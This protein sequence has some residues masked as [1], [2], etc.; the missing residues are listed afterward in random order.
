M[1]E[2]SRLGRESI[3]TSYALKEIL[4]AGVKVF[5][6]LENKERVLESAMDKIMLSLTSFSSEVER[7]RCRQRTHDALIRKV[8]MGHVAGGRVYGYD[9]VEIFNE[10]TDSSGEKKRQY[11]KLGVNENEAE[12]VRH[13]YQ[14]YADGWGVTKIAKHLNADAIPAPR[15]AKG[16]WAPSAIWEILHRSKYWGENIYNMYQN[17]Y[18]NGTQK[19]VKRPKE[20]WIINKDPK[21]RIISPEVEKRVKAR[22]EHNTR[23]YTNDPFTGRLIVGRPGYVE[24]NSPYLMTGLMECGICG[25]SM[26]AITRQL[27][28]TREKFYGCNYHLKRGKAICNNSLE[29]Q[30]D[31]IDHLVLEAINNVLDVPFLE[32]VV[33]KAVEKLRI[34][35]DQSGDR[36]TAIK[37]EIATI[38]GNIKNLLNAIKEGKAFKALVEAME[39]EEERKNTLQ[40]ELASLKSQNRKVAYLDEAKMKKE[41]RTRVSDVKG[42]P[43]FIKI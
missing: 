34:M 7:E 33:D 24:F 27:K 15:K 16:G 13:I 4:D 20:E 12:I 42:V 35:D 40:E 36:Q 8:K 11:V 23:V 6:Y 41:L 30:Q 21:L 10:T 14:K 43:I 22:I 39:V 9:N 38:D 2:E 37:K 29:I 19:R 25:G 26:V 28:R 1:S 32:E 18:V 31:I 17:I 3:Q 5:Y